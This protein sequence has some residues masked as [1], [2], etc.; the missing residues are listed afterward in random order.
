MAC[1]EVADG[2]SGLQQ[3]TAL[4]NMVDR[5]NISELA[6]RDG[7]LYKVLS[8]GLTTP[9]CKNAPLTKS[10]TKPLISTDSLHKRPQLTEIDIGFDMHMEC[11]KSV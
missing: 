9:R 2:D 11:E 4:T 7:P 5:I 3:R 6:K 8:V 10:Y 1:P